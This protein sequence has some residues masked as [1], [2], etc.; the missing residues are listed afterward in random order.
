MENKALVQQRNL[1]VI[2]SG[3]LKTMRPK[4]WT[5]NLLVFAGLIFSNN[6]FDYGLLGTTG[7]GFLLFCMFSGSVYIINDIIDLEKDRAHPKKRKRPIA[8]GLVS[9]R[10]A[11]FFLIIL[12]VTTVIVSFQLN[13]IFAYLGIAYFA[14]ITLYSF[15]LKHIV[16]LD[17]M[18]IAVGFVLRAVAGAVLVDVRISP[19][20]LLCTILLSMF[21]AL[22]KRKSE[23]KLVANGQ[24]TTRKI[25]EEY[26]PELIDD[27]LHIVTSSTVM[28]YSLYTF[29]SHNSI[30]MMATIPF[31]IYGIFRY[32]YIA[33]TKDMGETP[34]LVLLNDK[35]LIIDILLWVVS[36]VGILYFL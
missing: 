30:Y 1:F 3:L 18:T 28:A 14:L 34:E 5:K 24:K 4:Q 16:I 6:L 36:C 27:M 12:F 20:L 23:M 11:V 10:Q 21:L 25:L 2:I 35:P 8:S 32:Q 15:H 33:H 13:T 26:T 29:N 9:V 17:V 7:L 19:W 22:H 31:V